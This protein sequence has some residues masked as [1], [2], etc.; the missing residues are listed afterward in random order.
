MELV[1]ESSMSAVLESPE[2]DTLPADLGRAATARVEMYRW[3]VE[4][5]QQMVE[6]GILGSEDRVEL[7]EGVVVAK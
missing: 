5:Y 4:Q 2:V 1:P 3:S 6:A 7:L